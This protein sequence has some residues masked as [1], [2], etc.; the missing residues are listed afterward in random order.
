[1]VSSNQGCV[2]WLSA[3]TPLDLMTQIAKEWWGLV[4]S[5]LIRWMGRLDLRYGLKH[6]NWILGE[7]TM[8]RLSSMP[9]IELPE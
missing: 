6:F 7:S 8:P 5:W 9:L 3:V 4:C 1:M 2:H